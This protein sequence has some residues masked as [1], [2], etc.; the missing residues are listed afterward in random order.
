V[1]P[2]SRIVVPGLVGHE[3]VHDRRAEQDDLHE[4]LVLTEERSEP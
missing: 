4:V 1:R 3:R 2:A